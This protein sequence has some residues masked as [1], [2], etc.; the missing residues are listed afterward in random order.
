[1]AHAHDRGIVHRDL[2][3]ANILRVDGRVK[4]MDFGIA[5]QMDADTLT[6][7]YA[8]LGTP[9]YAAPEAQLKTR[10]G[11]EADLYSLGVLL[12]EMASGKP[13]FQGETPFEILD[14]HRKEDLPDLAALRPDLPA[15][16]IGLILG[17]CAKSPADRPDD[18]RTLAV[19]R[20]L[21]GKA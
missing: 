20:E 19:L 21:A 8:F 9:L 2:K 6:S 13:P 10:I 16:L 7:T 1:M 4:I 15:E 12:F 3:P 17:L 5:R 18:S 14:R 11:P